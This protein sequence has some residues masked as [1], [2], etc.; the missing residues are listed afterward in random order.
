MTLL[1][2]E[3]H[4]GFRASGFWFRLAGSSSRLVVAS[5]LLLGLGFSLVYPWLTRN[6][7][8]VT[9]SDLEA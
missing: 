2:E 8:S 6:Y 9:S 1:L 7:S 3:K 5:K 4:F